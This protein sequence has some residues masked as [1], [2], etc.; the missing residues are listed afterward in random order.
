MKVW[1]RSAPSPIRPRRTRAPLSRADRE[2]TKRTS[3]IFG[4]HHTRKTPPRMHTANFGPESNKSF[5]YNKSPLFREP[6]E[7]NQLWYLN[8][9]EGPSGAYFLC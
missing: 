9:Q 7:P 2:R 1:K 5:R 8:I 6:N 3:P 4:H